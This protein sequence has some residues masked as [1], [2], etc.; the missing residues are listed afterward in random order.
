MKRCEI[1]SEVRAPSSNG[2]IAEASSPIR[3]LF[4]FHFSFFTSHAFPCPV[5]TCQSP[6]QSGYR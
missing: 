5:Q 1:L 3:Q 2:L 6:R 4:T